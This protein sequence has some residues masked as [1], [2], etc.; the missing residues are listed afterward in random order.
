[1][2]LLGNTYS[3]ADPTDDMS[4]E[5]GKTRKVFKLNDVFIELFRISHRED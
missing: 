3:A 4:I 5:V 1:M 2:I